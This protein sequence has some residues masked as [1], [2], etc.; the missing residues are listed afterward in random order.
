[1]RGLLAEA[2]E[3]RHAEVLLVERR[4]DF[5]HDLLEAVGPHHVAILRHARDGFGDQ[6][7]GVPLLR[8]R[9]V[10]RL[11][12]AGEG[13]V[14]VVLVAVLHEQVARRLAD[15]DADDVLAVLLE[16]EHE[17]REVRVAGQQDI[18]ADFRAGEDQLDRIHREA[19]VGGVLLGRAVG[20]GE[21]QVDGRFRQ[22]DDVLRVAP[23]IGVRALH[24]DLAA[25]DVGR[26]QVAQLRLQIGADAHRDVVKIDEQGR[27]GCGVWR[28]DSGGGVRGGL[29]PAVQ[30]S[31][32]DAER[33]APLVTNVHAFSR[34]AG[35]KRPGGEH[36]S[37]ALKTGR[38]SCPWLV[39]STGS[40]PERQWGQLAG[41]NL[42]VRKGPRARSTGFR[43]CRE[44]RVAR[45]L[46]GPEITGEADDQ[47]IIGNV[48]DLWLSNV[49]LAG[50]RRHP[51]GRRRWP[52]PRAG[53][54]FR[55]VVSF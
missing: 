26:Q 33:R 34:L 15:A 29:W 44:T 10:A 6:L 50:L 30:R 55:R 36:A 53:S 48:R 12:E 51:S 25:D 16:L 17:R 14:A 24:G 28:G 37:A 3:L 8:G 54:K 43:R 13:V 31:D 32:G 22:R 4:V 52:Q 49:T 35:R 2:R 19:D 38:G 7:P 40:P 9:L 46:G 41:K 39:C 23:P 21:D 5:L 47:L 42:R 20:R 45:T 27:V 18:R 1:M 11:H